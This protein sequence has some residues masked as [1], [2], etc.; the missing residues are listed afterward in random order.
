LKRARIAAALWG[1]FLF[2]VTSWPH[3]PEIRAGGFPL[4]K[5]THFLLY[6][7]EAFLL[8]RAIATPGRGF[9]WS[10][11]LGVVGVM[12][13]WGVLD[14]VHQ[15]WIPGRRMDGADLGADVAGAVIGA[16]AAALLSPRALRA[17]SR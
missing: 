6:G 7:V 8:H 16:C 5:L 9:A 11:V 1:G 3:P 2:A 17:L 10:R 13:V 14:E 4:D 12:A 15:E